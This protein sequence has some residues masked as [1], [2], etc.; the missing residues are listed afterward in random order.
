[1]NVGLHRDKLDPCL[2][3]VPVFY[4][5]LVRALIFQASGRMKGVFVEPFWE[6][7]MLFLLTKGQ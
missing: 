3:L 5:I 4:E 1:M 7:S 6:G 2:N